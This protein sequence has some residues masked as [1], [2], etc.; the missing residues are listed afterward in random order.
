MTMG[1]VT[2]GSVMSVS[3]PEKDV[4]ASRSTVLML[5]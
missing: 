2:P 4:I 3:L 5:M 1:S